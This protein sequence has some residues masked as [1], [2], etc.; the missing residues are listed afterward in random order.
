MSKLKILVRITLIYLAIV[1]PSV[2]MKFDRDYLY[3]FIKSYVENNISV[4]AQGKLKVE[5]SKIDPRISLQSCLSTLTANIPE[6]HNGRNVNVKI[7]CPDEDPWQLFIPVRIQT[8]IPVLV[9]RMRINKGTL[10]NNTNIEII[11]KDSGKIRGTVLTNPKIVTGARTK[12]NLS[13]GSAITNK[14]TC[15]VC[16]GEPVS[17]IAKSDNFE[18][19]SNGIAL[20]D[21]SLGD[22]ISV[23]NKKSGRVVQGQV[24]AINRVVINL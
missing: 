10:L 19:K 11:F 3:N 12:R 8:I 7:I 18:I 13:Q 24:N 5:V 17:I 20:K 23:R 22:I 4:P 15:F 9:T 1:N 21:G 6:N 16:K 2:A 14:N